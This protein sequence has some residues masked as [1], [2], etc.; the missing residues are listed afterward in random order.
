MIIL[1]NFNKLLI[2]YRNTE[3][4]TGIKEVTNS[5]C[6]N[7]LVVIMHTAIVV[8]QVRL[9]CQKNKLC[10]WPLVKQYTLGGYSIVSP[11]LV[12]LGKVVTRSRCLTIMATPDVEGCCNGVRLYIVEDNKLCH[13]FQA[14]KF[15]YLACIALSRD[16]TLVA[17]MATNGKTVKLF[18]SQGFYL[19]FN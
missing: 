2:F 12:S 8:Y 11:R 6:G 5:K 9:C 13:S 1:K 18:N 16:A 19:N 7:S 14:S 3:A 15:P 10:H 4:I 17:T